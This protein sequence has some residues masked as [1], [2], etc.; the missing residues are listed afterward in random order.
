MTGSCVTNPGDR[1]AIPTS[2]IPKPSLAVSGRAEAGVD[3][4]VFVFLERSSLL[5]LCLVVGSSGDP[6]SFFTMIFG[7]PAAFLELYSILARQEE[8]GGQEKSSEQKKF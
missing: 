8:R 4:P 5:G 7:G 2:W 3:D 1:Q 6:G